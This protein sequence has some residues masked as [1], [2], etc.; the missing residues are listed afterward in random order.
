MFSLSTSWWT[1]LLFYLVHLTMRRTPRLL[2]LFPF[3]IEILCFFLLHEYVNPCC[4]KTPPDIVYDHLY[5]FKTWKWFCPARPLESILTCLSWQ[6]KVL[7]TQLDIYLQQKDYSFHFGQERGTRKSIENMSKKPFQ[8]KFYSC[9]IPC[10]VFR[11]LKTMT[12]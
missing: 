10:N 4:C 5:R 11:L 8:K 2:S 12:D 3:T 6:V 9:H 1:Q 7:V